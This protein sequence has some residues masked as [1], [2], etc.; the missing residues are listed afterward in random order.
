MFHYQEW[1]VAQKTTQSQALAAQERPFVPVC[2]AAEQ[3][4]S[5]F[6][7]DTALCLYSTKHKPPLDNARGL[8]CRIHSLTRLPGLGRALRSFGDPSSTASTRRHFHRA[9]GQEPRSSSRPA[10]KRLLCHHRLPSI[11]RAGER[12]PPRLGSSF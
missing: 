1:V 6:P 10:N 12:L 9:Q 7:R 3:Q 11:T 5:L 4:G 8:P 2:R